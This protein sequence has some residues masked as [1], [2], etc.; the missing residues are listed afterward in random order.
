[1]QECVNEPP[2]LQAGYVEAKVACLTV[3]ATCMCS[4]LKYEIPLALLPHF[5]CLFGI[6]FYQ[7]GCEKKYHSWFK[8]SVKHFESRPCHLQIMEH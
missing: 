3:L 5:N 2:F 6:T 8:M 4:A 7:R 1:M